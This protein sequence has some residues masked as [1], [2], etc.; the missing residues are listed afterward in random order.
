M[1]KVVLKGHPLTD[2]VMKEVKGGFPNVSNYPENLVR[3]EA[4][5]TILLGEA[6]PN[7]EFG[8]LYTLFCYKCGATVDIDKPQA[9]E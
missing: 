6:T 9:H 4:C 3:C 1:K 2:D 7:D 8:G 5:G